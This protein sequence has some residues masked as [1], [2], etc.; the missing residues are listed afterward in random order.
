MTEQQR[1]LILELTRG[2]ISRDT[3]LSQFDPR[4]TAKPDQIIAL[5][6]EAIKSRSASEVECSLY[7]IYQF[8]DSLES[9]VP[10]LVQLFAEDW[11]HRHEDIALAF[12]NLKD[13]RAIEILY[14]TAL[15]EFEYLKYD[16][17]EA[18]ARKCTWALARIGTV[19]ALDKL[20]LLANCEKPVV[21]AF[22]RKRLPEYQ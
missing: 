6:Q 22:A 9:Y 20:R 15:R 10:V 5:I 13:P 4:F 18:L 19:E 17:S 1:N 3:F 7:L 12:E 2:K 8:K 21:C 16:N 11:H 14:Q